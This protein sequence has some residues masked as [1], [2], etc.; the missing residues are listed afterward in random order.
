MTDTADPNRFGRV[1]DPNRTDFVVHPMSPRVLATAD[2]RLE[3]RPDPHRETIDFLFGDGPPD[4]YAE[5]SRRRRRSARGRPLGRTPR[6]VD[7]LGLINIERTVVESLAAG[8]GVASIGALARVRL[9]RPRPQ[10]PL[11]RRPPPAE[12]QARPPRLGDPP[13]GSTGQGDAP[14]CDRAIAFRRAPI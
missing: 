14:G 9:G 13:P 5:A 7:E 6:L 11:R 2:G 10:R 8:E 4:A 12:G 3:L 1:D